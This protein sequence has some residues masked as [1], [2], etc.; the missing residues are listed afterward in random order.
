MSDYR[1]WDRKYSKY[2][3]LD[4]AATALPCLR[5]LRTYDWRS[6]L[7]VCTL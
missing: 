7:A 3:A 6:S 5:W 4:W 1:R 2:D